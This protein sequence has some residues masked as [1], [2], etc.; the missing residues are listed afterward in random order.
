[1]ADESIN[2]QSKFQA[3]ID[4]AKERVFRVM[5]ELLKDRKQGN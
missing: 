4:A 3:I 2:N 1:M 5:A